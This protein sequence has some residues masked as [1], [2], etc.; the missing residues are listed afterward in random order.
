MVSFL[1]QYT[2]CRVF[3][4]ESEE[5][6][7]L[8]LESEPSEDSTLTQNVTLDG[9]GSSSGPVSTKTVTVYLGKME[10]S[11]SGSMKIIY[12]LR[13]F[14]FVVFMSSLIHLYAEILCKTFYN[15]F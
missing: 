13:P 14:G 11:V 1:K 12:S 8:R 3:R 10:E 5:E 7:P 4:P 6:I 9:T 15:R 2:L